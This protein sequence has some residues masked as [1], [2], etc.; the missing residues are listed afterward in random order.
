MFLRTFGSRRPPTLVI[1]G[2]VVLNSMYINAHPPTGARHQPSSVIISTTTQSERDERRQ[3]TEL[4]PTP[5]DFYRQVT[6]TWSS[7][8]A[9][10]GGAIRSACDCRGLFGRQKN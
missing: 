4:A 8:L 9:H 3:D 10:V 2:N 5:V 6:P 7:R 1:R